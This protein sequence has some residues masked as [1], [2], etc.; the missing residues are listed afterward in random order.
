[1]TWG[2]NGNN[3]AD[4]AERNEAI[5]TAYIL[6]RQRRTVVAREFGISV[7]RVCQIVH[8]FRKR[9][10]DFVRELEGRR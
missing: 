8:R 6:Y 10:P 9:R 4:F 5:V 1:M 7:T 2:D 3:P